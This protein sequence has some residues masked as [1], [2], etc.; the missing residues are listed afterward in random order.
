VAHDVIPE[1]MMTKDELTDTIET[2]VNW[3]YGS[4]DYAIIDH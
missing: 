3:Y 4:G 1:E 2:L